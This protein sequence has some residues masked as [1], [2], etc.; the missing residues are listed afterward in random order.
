MKR[1]AFLMT[2]TA[3]PALRAAGEAQAKGGMRLGVIAMIGKDPE[4]GVR[5][6]HD[7]GFPTCQLYAGSSDPALAKPV[8]AALDRYG[9]ECTS[10]IGGGPGPEIYDFYR[11]PST[12]GFVPRE[13]RAA[14]I[15]SIKKTSDF[16]KLCGIA[17]VQTHC[18]FIPENPNEPLYKEAVAAIREV[19]AYCKQNHQ[20]FRC[21][22]GQETPITLVRAIR[23]VGVEGLG[24]NFDVGNLILYGKANPVDAVE[25]LAPYIQGVHAKDG[26]YPVDP[27][28]LGREV[29]IG[30]GKVNFPALIKKLKE[31]GYHGALTIEREIEGPD[32]QR[33]ILASKALLEKLI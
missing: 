12:I 17:A 32:Q 26:L 2:A 22:T 20:N 4:A 15:A 13:T 25:L 3:L 23:D 24:V 29:P 30:Q 28:E 11:G 6:V 27:K 8:R 33:D 1:R 14:R 31:A 7:L 18:G 16:A 21:E 5:R 9:I 10:M 19:A